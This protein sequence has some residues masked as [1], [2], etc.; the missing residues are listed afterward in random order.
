MFYSNE[1]QNTRKLFYSSWAKYQK[2]Q[3]LETLEKQIVDVILSHPEYH[4]L[5]EN[6]SEDDTTYF[7][8]LGQTNPFL[9]MGLHLALR[10]QIGTNRPSGI[11]A[12]FQQLSNKLG[13]SLSVEHKMMECLVECL[14]LAQK[15][16]TI[17]DEKHYI[18]KLT[19]MANSL[20]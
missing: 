19:D 1:V 8:E 17:P 7:P 5:L 20:V 15:N 11:K 6:A 14:W 18:S 10:E 3:P 13:D 12:V 4:S 9:H 2:K 16:Q